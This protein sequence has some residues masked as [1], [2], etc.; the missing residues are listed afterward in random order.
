MSAVL[1]K[2]SIGRL[3]LA[4]PV[5]G[6]SLVAKVEGGAELAGTR[7]RID[8]DLQRTDGTAGNV[9]L[10]MQLGGDPPVLKLELAAAEPTG[11]LTD[12]L[13]GRTD[14][15]P[16]KVSL[17]GAGP[18][19]DWHGRL[20]V[21][22]GTIANVEAQVS[23]AAAE[24]TVLG[25]SGSAAL[26][27]LL[28]AE[29]APLAGDRV[30]FSLRAKFD[31]GVAVDPLSIETAAGKISGGAAFG[32]PDKAI[33]AHLRADLPELIRLAGVLG[34]PLEGSATLDF[35]WPEPKVVPILA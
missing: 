9:R 19:A 8:L 18:L 31:K 15:Q 17:R 28:P 3:A 32:A 11:M 7:A 16:L 12:R 33:S 1:D 34:Q 4:P 29:V 22:A 10:A 35:R 25:L 24:N 21:A 13:L 27:P 2:L 5:L 26:A 30:A 20:A 6:E 14:R 23:L